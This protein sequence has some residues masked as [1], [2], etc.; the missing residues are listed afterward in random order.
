MM[1]LLQNFVPGRTASFYD[2]IANG[3]GVGVGL[4]LGLSRGWISTKIKVISL[5]TK[6]RRH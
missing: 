3:L 1:E 5:A 4:S 6:S 2:A